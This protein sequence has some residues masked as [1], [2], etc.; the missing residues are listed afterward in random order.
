MLIVQARFAEPERRT[1][2]AVTPRIESVFI[3]WGDR[4]GEGPSAGAALRDLL[5]SGPLGAAGDTSVAGRWREAQR[6]AA[7]MDAALG[8]KDMVEFGRLYRRLLEALGLPRPK[9][10]P[11]P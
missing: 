2:D 10:A 7:E 6:I 3:T 4:N 11:G 8:R 5:S 9:L 1:G